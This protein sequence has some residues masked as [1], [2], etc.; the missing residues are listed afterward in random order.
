[1]TQLFVYGSLL[2]HATSPMG[3]AERVRLAAEAHYLGPA[4]TRGVL[5]NLGDYPGLIEGSDTV[6]GGLYQ[7]HTP[8][9]TLTW[10]DAYEGIAGRPSDD[11][12]RCPLPIL[13]PGLIVITAQAYVFIGPRDG[14]NAIPTGRWV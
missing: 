7:L 11:Y 10:L 14:L 6:Y 5:L 2:P 13:Q 12:Q 4:H 1:M 9:K 3:A 8:A